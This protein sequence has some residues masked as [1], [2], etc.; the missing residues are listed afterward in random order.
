[1]ISQSKVSISVE[2]IELSYKKGRSFFGGTQH[3]IFKGLSFDIFEGESLGII[4]RNGAGKSTL[5]RL[6][7]GV[8]SP[9]K[10]R[11]QADGVSSALLALGAGFNHDLDGRI[12]ILLNGM[13]LGFSKK[14]VEDKIAEIIDFSELSDAIDDPLKTYSSGMRSRLAFS[15]AIQMCPDVLLIDEALGVGDAGFLEKSGRALRERVQSKQT[16]V[17]VSHHA[18]TI[19]DLCNRVI[20]IEDGVLRKEGDATEVLR[21]YEDYI[22][23]HPPNAAG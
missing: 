5:L 2:N 12:N 3:E 15:I 18:E 4:G 1:M 8:I 23:S 22:I 17:L 10:G 20:W 7:A 19:K 21:E 16:V 9:D 14:K 11:I 13:L 6:L